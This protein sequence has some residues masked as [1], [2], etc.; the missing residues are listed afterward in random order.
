[1]MCCQARRWNKLTPTAESHCPTWHLAEDEQI[2]SIG[3]SGHHDHASPSLPAHI[4]IGNNW[5]S[6]LRIRHSASNVTN[7]DIKQILRPD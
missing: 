3:G 1:M 4:S 6:L 5:V 7:L 2:L